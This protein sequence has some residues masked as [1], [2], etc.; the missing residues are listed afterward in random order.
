VPGIL[1]CLVSLSG[2]L[3]RVDLGSTGTVLSRTIPEE[4]VARFDSFDCKGMI[5]ILAS[6][7]NRVGAVGGARKSSNQVIVGLSFGRCSQQ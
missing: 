4:P 6:A 1:V 2:W 5:Q 3:W 7:H